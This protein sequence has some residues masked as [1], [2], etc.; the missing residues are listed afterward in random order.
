MFFVVALHEKRV[1]G[2]AAADHMEIWDMGAQQGVSGPER[3]Q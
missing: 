1:A 3:V 2:N